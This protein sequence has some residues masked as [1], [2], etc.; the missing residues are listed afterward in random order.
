MRPLDRCG[1][2]SPSWLAATALLLVY[3]VRPG[4]PLRWHALGHLRHLQLHCWVPRLSTT[5]L[6]APFH[7]R[8]S[9]VSSAGPYSP[10]CT[11]TRHQFTGAESTETESLNHGYKFGQEEETYNIVA[12][13]ATLGRL[14]LQYASSTQPPACTFLLAAG[15]VVRHSGFA[16][17]ALAS[18]SFKPQRP[19]LQPL[20]AGSPRH[21]DQH[22][23]D[24]LNRGGL[25]T[26]RCT[27]GTC[28]NFRLIWPPAPDPRAWDGHQ[29]WLPSGL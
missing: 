21:G 2:L 10:P 13:T 5:L 6:I 15:P 19:Q 8:E 17:L 28:T 1:L 4:P 18:F 27:S 25:G 24:V 11:L 22:L 9:P 29:D 14:I 20:R 3:S 23:A 7:M 26:R 12:A 16:A